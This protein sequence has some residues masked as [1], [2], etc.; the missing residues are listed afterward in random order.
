MDPQQRLTRFALSSCE[1]F[2]VDC[3]AYNAMRY[4][5]EPITPGEILKDDYL[6]PLEISQNALGRALGVSP[7]AINEIVHGRRSITAQM[8]IRLGAYFRQSPRFW[9]NIQTECDIRNAMREQKKLT[10]HIKPMESVAESST[11]YGK[12]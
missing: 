5:V 9:L 3:V 12:R 7:R 10:A 2:A 6:D 4:G 1:K 11:E 8:S